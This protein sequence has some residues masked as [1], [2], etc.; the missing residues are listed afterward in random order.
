MDFFHHCDL[1]A[2]QTDRWWI[3]CV[4]YHYRPI[5]ALLLSPAIWN[6]VSR[7]RFTLLNCACNCM[8]IV[9][10][11][12][13]NKARPHYLKQLVCKHHKLVLMAWTVNMAN[14]TLTVNF[15]SFFSDWGT[16]ICLS[17][18]IGPPIISHLRKLL[19]CNFPSGNVPRRLQAYWKWLPWCLQWLL[20]MLGALLWLREGNQDERH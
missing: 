18:L 8:A 15:P 5:S 2:C 4:T 19:P 10:L 12:L 1:P 14:Y 17:I 11:T 6:R 13:L 16:A 20:N 3:D 7:P 9:L